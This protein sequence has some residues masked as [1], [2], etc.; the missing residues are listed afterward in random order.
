MILLFSRSSTLTGRVEAACEDGLMPLP[1]FVVNTHGFVVRDKRYLMIVRGDSE[2]QAPGVLSAP[3]GKVEHGDEMDNVLEETLR[4]EILEETGVV[5]GE[6][7][8]IRSSG[9]TLET[10]EPVV[11]IGFLCQFKSGH[12]R[13]ADR[14]EVAS[15]DWLTPEEI[16]AHDRTPLWTRATLSAAETLRQALGW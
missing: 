3:G 2:V 5:I 8:Y 6:V 15:A 10:G 1:T 13:V 16:D 12:A 9:F 4:R 14:N 7:A 11:D